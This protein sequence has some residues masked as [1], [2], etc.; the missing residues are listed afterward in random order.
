MR[1]VAAGAATLAVLFA[2]APAYAEVSRGQAGWQ[3]RSP[4]ATG[5]LVRRQAR[6]LGANA[7][8]TRSALRPARPAAPA[9]SRGILSTYEAQVVRRINAIR[10]SRGQR[11][12]R[13]SRQ[14]S[15]AAAYHTNQ[16]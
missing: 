1:T 10:R 6:P 14:L 11:A 16:M 4:A 5:F 7:F 8:V 13:V 15:A 12:L 3:L 9:V 2:A